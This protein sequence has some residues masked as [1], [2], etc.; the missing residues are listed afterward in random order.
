MFGSGC[1]G[2][3]GL[4][5]IR[6]AIHG[7]GDPGRFSRRMRRSCQWHS[8]LFGGAITLA[9]I[10][11]STRSG[12]VLPH[13]HTPSR[14]G[15]DVI[16]TVGGGT[17]VLASVAVASHD[18]A[19]RQSSSPV[20]RHSHH[21]TQTNDERRRQ[22][23]S[24]GP[25]VRAIVFDEV[26]L[27]G[28][29]E[30]SCSPHRHDAQRLVRGV[31]NER[32]FHGYLTAC[33]KLRLTC[34]LTRHRTF[35]TTTDI[36]PRRAARMRAQDLR[37]GWWRASLDTSCSA[38]GGTAPA[39]TSVEGPTPPL[40]AMR[41]TTNL[42]GA[43]QPTLRRSSYS[44]LR[45]HCAARHTRGSLGKPRTISPVMLRWICDEPA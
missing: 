41:S 45:V 40:D 4:P 10:A 23:K 29:N 1:V 3:V 39:P 33:L 42:D 20:I 18:S 15:H 6:Y 13:M 11:G 30:A 22:C 26:G 44:R 28:E 19:T 5:L 17:A 14:T 31:E 8:C 7:H 35:C 24:F 2:Q 27:V 16:D 32:A 37:I 12:H 34:R 21:V 9:E 25:H 38:V 36:S 43:T